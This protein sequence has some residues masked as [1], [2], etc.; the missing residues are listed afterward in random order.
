MCIRDRTAAVQIGTTGELV[1]KDIKD[2]TVKTYDDILLAF[3]DLKAGR[4]DSCLLYTSRC[5]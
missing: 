2:V 1:A 3:E 5:V 4:V